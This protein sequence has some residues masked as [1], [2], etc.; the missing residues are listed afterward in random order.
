[1]ASGSVDID[2]T[3][4]DEE[5]DEQQQRPAKRQR[6]WLGARNQ[7]SWYGGEVVL[8][9]QPEPLV[10]PA[11]AAAGQPPA[12]AA[13]QPQPAA[14]DAD[15]DDDVQLVGMNREVSLCQQAR[16]RICTAA[17]ELMR[18]LTGGACLSSSLLPTTTLRAARRAGAAVAHRHA[19]PPGDVRR[20]PL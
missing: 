16:T 3:L 4:E 13:G 5:D 7:T 19:S 1:M 9:E 2:L 18:D 12:L 10:Q 14:A 20:A 17:T 15:E 11:A 8:V 6:P